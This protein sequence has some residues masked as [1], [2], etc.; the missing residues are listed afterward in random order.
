MKR[1][2]R[3][4]VTLAL[5]LLAV[6]CL[7]LVLSL[8][9]PSPYII[10]DELLYTKLAR[11]LGEHHTTLFRGAV[12]NFPAVLYPLLLVP[13]YLAPDPTWSF[14]LAQL[15][16]ALLMTSAGLPIALIAN[17]LLGRKA[18]IPVAL[19]LM[20]APYTLYSNV[21]MS[22]N[23]FFPLVMWAAYLALC[24]MDD[25]RP[26][27]KLA[28]GLVLG[29]AFLAKPHGLLLPVAVAA[30]L[31]AAL[32]GQEG[33]PRELARRIWAYWPALLAYAGILVLHV[34]KTNT[35][36][37]AASWFD[38][39]GFFGSYSGGFA[40]LRAFDLALFLRS[41]LA[42]LGAIATSLSIAPAVLYGFFLWHAARRGTMA[43]R[44]F[45]AFSAT[46]AILLVAVTARHTVTL[47]DPSRIHE[48]YCFHLAP[49]FLIGGLRSLAMSEPNRRAWLF[50]TAGLALV[51]PWLA[52]MAA[53]TP[54]TA[55]TP[56]L[57]FM[58]GVVEK[59]GTAQGLLLIIPFSL[60]SALILGWLLADRRWKTAAA[61]GLGY[62]TVLSGG[63]AYAQHHSSETHAATL[64]LVRWVNQH[65]PADA[66]IA[67][68]AT[69]EQFKN[70]LVI[71]F[72]TRQPS[73]LFYVDAQPLHGINDRS[74]DLQPSGE[75][76]G[77]SRLPE[78]A[79]LMVPA[80]MQLALPVLS[81][82]G[83][84]VLYEKL[85]P[86]RLKVAGTAHIK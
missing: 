82:R 42:N 65:A 16:N 72:Y 8:W 86:V 62:S 69:K 70:C 13:A 2:A 71:E 44:S 33:S 29:L 5:V 55:D 21:A 61:I 47:D 31:L 74:V 34:I 77:L 59:L 52:V 19:L 60:F 51:V 12:L 20:A 30:S 54:Y 17:R 39:S 79:R 73:W 41:V 28:L 58:S 76:A 53:P 75:L 78:G 18:A 1:E 68:V 37:G 43:D 25:R 14:R 4:P 36:L 81:T 6:F 10:T 80:S 45:A 7:R 83:D 32:P 48:R 40:S 64:P 22:E 26:W 24:P 57:T 15:T 66:P 49:L 23:V 85:G 50:V 35:L 63:M 3:W 27:H 46:L 38:L 67:L 9:I 56:S 11:S 84:L